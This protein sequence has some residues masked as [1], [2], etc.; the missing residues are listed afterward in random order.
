MKTCITFFTAY[1]FLFATNIYGAEK[2]D[3]LNAHLG[4]TA[5]FMLGVYGPGWHKDFSGHSFAT[6]INIPLSRAFYI[7]P[8]FSYVSDKSSSMEDIWVMYSTSTAPPGFYQL[9]APEFD[10][11][12]IYHM[13]TNVA[14]LDLMLC[15]DVLYKFPKHQLILGFGYGVKTSNY[16]EESWDIDEDNNDLER[17][18]IQHESHTYVRYTW[19]VAYTYRLTD[20][21]GIGFREFSLGSIKGRAYNTGGVGLHCSIKL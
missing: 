12:N 15:V 14:A 13:Q 17:Y 10:R 2:K 9:N 7:R 5:E 1:L 16:M 4:L 8:R 6:N 11:E 19:T 21:I 20:K 3:S 18:S